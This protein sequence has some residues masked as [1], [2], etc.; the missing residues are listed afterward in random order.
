MGTGAVAGFP[1]AGA[2]FTAD[3]SIASESLLR[4]ADETGAPGDAVFP[5]P[6]STVVALTAFFLPFFF[7][8][9]GGGGAP[10]AAAHGADEADV[11]PC[12]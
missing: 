8:G 11:F 9:G 6:L 12:W 4:S 2:A 5:A 10:M 1:G 7:G 3:P